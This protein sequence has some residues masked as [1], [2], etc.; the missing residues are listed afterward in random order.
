MIPINRLFSAVP[1]YCLFSAFV[2]VYPMEQNAPIPGGIIRV[3]SDVTCDVKQTLVPEGLKLEHRHVTATIPIP[4]D[5]RWHMVVYDFNDDLAE[6]ST[7]QLHP[8]K[9][10][11]GE[12]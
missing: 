3:R 2:M 4:D 1:L 7:M 10:F 6:V 5:G 12:Y 11:V 8:V 9:R